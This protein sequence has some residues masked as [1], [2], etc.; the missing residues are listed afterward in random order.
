MSIEV[1]NP[2][3]PPFVF[4]LKIHCIFFLILLASYFHQSPK[5]R[6]IDGYVLKVL[7]PFFGFIGATPSSAPS[8]SFKHL[9]SNTIAL[10]KETH[11]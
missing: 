4:S 6:R 9:L 11:P 5:D 7:P 10:Q 2:E 1:A 3:E 8:Q